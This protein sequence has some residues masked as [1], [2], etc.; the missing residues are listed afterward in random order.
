MKIQN[1]DHLLF[2]IKFPRRPILNFL[3]YHCQ[4]NRPRM[5]TEECDCP[6]HEGNKCGIRVFSDLPELAIVS[7]VVRCREQYTSKSAMWATIYSEIVGNYYLINTSVHK[8]TKFNQLEYKNFLYEYYCSD[9]QIAIKPVTSDKNQPKPE[10]VFPDPDIRPIVKKIFEDYIDS[11]VLGPRPQVKDGEKPRPHFIDTMVKERDGVP[12]LKYLC[13]K[14]IHF[15]WLIYEPEMVN[16]IP[17]HRVR[18]TSNNLGTTQFIKL[19]SEFGK[20][21]TY[22]GHNFD[23]LMKS[24]PK[25]NDFMMEDLGTRH[26]IKK[27][28]FRYSP[29]DLLSQMKLDTGGGIFPTSKR[30]TGVPG[31][32][33]KNTGKKLFMIIPA[34]IEFDKYVRK[35]AQGK[36]AQLNPVGVTRTKF[37]WRFFLVELREKLLA[38]QNKCRE[39]F[40][41]SILIFFLSLIF[42]ARRKFETGRTIMIGMKMFHGGAYEIALKMNYNNPEIFWWSGDIEKY[43]KSVGDI[44]IMDYCANNRMYYDFENYDAFKRMMFEKMMKDWAYHITNKVVCFADDVW[45]I[46]FGVVASGKLETSHIDSWILKKYFYYF[47]VVIIAEYPE[48]DEVI[49]EAVV[50][51]FLRMIVYG[52]DHIGCCPKILRGIINVNTWASFLKTHCRSILRDYREYDTFLSVPNLWTGGLSYEGP[53][54]CKRYF[55]AG[56]D[57]KLAPVLPYKPLLEPMLRVFVNTNQEPID[58]LLSIVGHMWDTMGTNKRHYDMLLQFYQLLNTE[59]KVKSVRELY[60]IARQDP[61]RKQ[62]LNRMIRKINLSPELIYESVPSYESIRKRNE[63]NPRACKFGIDAYDPDDI[64]LFNF[65]LDEQEFY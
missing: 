1:L 38:A 20:D 8:Y 64:E 58:Y 29:I 44:W 49:T 65:D 43:D 50:H 59:L 19:Y 6:F 4:K 11:A 15:E 55:I 54:F 5:K 14:K 24:L 12:T 39:F 48:L 53:K 28:D 51:G 60:E 56:D 22:R 62:K 40:I 21:T 63:Y 42:G 18:Y 30:D 25:I 31:L 46:L 32:V 41:L 10:Q 47:L 61:G 9:N 3:F 27:V 17:C 33:N 16:G 57:P 26:Y 23:M 35:V 36:D 7:P 45:R 52:D 13:F 2:K 34:L 37:E